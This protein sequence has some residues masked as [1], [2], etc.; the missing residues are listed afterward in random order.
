MHASFTSCLPACSP[1]RFGPFCTQTC[2]CANSLICDR[3]TGDCVC[4]SGGDGCKQGKEAGFHNLEYIYIYLSYV[5]TLAPRHLWEVIEGCFSF[6]T[7]VTFPPA[8]WQSHLS[9]QEALWFLFLPVKGSRGE[10]SVASSCSSSWW[11]CCWSCCCCTVTGRRT[12]RTTRQRF[13]SPPAAPSTLN[14]LFQVQH[15]CHTVSHTP[16]ACF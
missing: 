6:C 8:V 7:S 2:S 14:T 9:C 10:P 5:A 11:S 4:E 13:P 3:F 12:S 1:G 15:I 16:H